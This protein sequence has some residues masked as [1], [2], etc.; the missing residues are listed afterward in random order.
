MAIEEIKQA[1]H[2]ADLI[3]RPYILV[4]NPSEEDK[5]KQVLKDTEYENMVIVQP[6]SAVEMG[7]AFIIDR[8]KLEDNALPKID[9]N[10]DIPWAHNRFGYARSELEG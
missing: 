7:K 6:D 1:I 3:L 9:F 10:C 5:F 2:K 4:V 8:K